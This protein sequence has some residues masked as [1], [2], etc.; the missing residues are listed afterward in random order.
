MI[1]RRLARVPPTQPSAMPDRGQALIG[2]VG[3]QGQ[4]IL[5]ARGE[6]AIGLADA[7]GDEV[8]DHH[9]EI[10]RG[11]VEDVALGAASAT[12]GVEAGD[13]ALGARLFVAGGA[14][15]LTGK[16]QARKLLQFER[17]R[18]FARVDV[19]VFD[20]V[21]GPG[22]RH[23]FEARD[24]LQRDRAER[25]RAARSRCRSDRSCRRRGL[26]VPGRSGGGRGR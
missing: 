1:R 13:E 22:H 23:V 17:R 15:D 3:A 21:A 9:A 10:A 18:Q 14:V 12:G 26:R 8:V 4:A 16:E 6:H 24:R 2:V 20:R 11:A 7:A 5:G 19:V 25:L